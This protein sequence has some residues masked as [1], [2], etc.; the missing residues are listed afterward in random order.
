VTADD[1]KKNPS[2]GYV[3]SK[4]LAEKAAWQYMEKEKPGFTLSVVCLP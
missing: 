2:V 1:V 4:T 3:A